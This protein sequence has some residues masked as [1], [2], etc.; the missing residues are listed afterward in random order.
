MDKLVRTLASKAKLIGMILLFAATTISVITSA[1][2]IGGDFM[3]VVGGI[4]LL[5]V[6][7][8]MVGIVPLLIALK[9][10][11]LVKYAFAPVFGY[12]IISSVFNFIGNADM[13][14]ANVSGIVVT[15]SLF[16]FIAG[17]ALLAVIVMAVLFFITKQ[18]KM[19]QIGFCILVGALVFFSLAWVM[20]I[21]AYAKNGAGWAAYF[22]A[23]F[24]YWFFPIGLAFVALDL[25][26]SGNA[27]GAPKAQ[28]AKEGNE[29]A[30]KN[31][32]QDS[33]N[34]TITD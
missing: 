20:W 24:R 3:P 21:A 23:F 27:L 4:I 5:L 6:E 26:V 29:N 11:D 15:A 34:K 14:T 1:A 10:Y 28:K 7:L 17:V 8:V 9:K 33:D 19:L 13:I 12:W 16:D 22:D 31:E 18:K 32:K 2:S 30:V 25:L